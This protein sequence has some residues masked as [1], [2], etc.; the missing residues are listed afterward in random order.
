[1]KTNKL[2]SLAIL[3]AFAVSTSVLS[4]ATLVKV[5][6]ARDGQSYN[7]DISNTNAVREWNTITT[8][9]THWDLEV[10]SGTAGVGIDTGYDLDL[11]SGW[12]VTSTNGIDS[13]VY[14]AG[15][16]DD[17]TGD[18]RSGANYDAMR[19]VTAGDTVGFT[20][21]GFNTTDTV[22]IQLG[23]AVRDGS[24]SNVADF[25]FAG[26]TS[27]NGFDVYDNSQAGGTITGAIMT[28]TLTGAS[29]YTFSMDTADGNTA[30][31]NA[32]VMTVTPVPEPSTYALLAGLLGL[33]H[34]MMR[35]RRA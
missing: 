30:G 25:S 22:S 6:F 19:A 2:S 1:M 14:N 35:R 33:G 26:S 15:I 28:W 9:G 4:A 3:S 13:N 12:G 8:S 20:L 24:P 11:T 21:S 17:V 27:Y 31:I 7:I 10:S 34:V 5:D 29:S 16:F 18:A 23:A 32:M